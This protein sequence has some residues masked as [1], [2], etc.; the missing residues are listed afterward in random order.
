MVGYLPHCTFNLNPRAASIDTPLHAFVPL[1]ACRPH[2]SRRGHRHRR[3]RRIRSALTKEIFGDEIGWL[4]WQRP[5]FELGLELEAIRRGQ[6]EANGVVLESHGL[7]TWGD[8]AK[9]MLR[10]DAR[11]SSTRRSP[12]STAQTAGKPAFG[13]ARRS[14]RS[15]A[16]ERRAIAAR[17]MPAIRGLISKSERKVGHSTISRRARI[18][19]LRRSRRA[20]RARHLLPRP[21]PAHQDPAAGPR[22][23][24]GSRDVDAVI[25]RLADGARRLSRRLRRLLRALQARRTSP[26]MRDPNAVVYLV[27]GV[28]M[29][30][31][32]SD[33]ATARIAGEFYVNAINVMR[34]ASSVSTYRRPARAGGLRHRVLAAR[35][36]QA[37]AHAEAEEP[38]RP[39]RARHRR[40]RRHRPRHGRRGCCARAPASCSPTSTQAALDA[41]V[42]EFGKRLRQGC[43]ARRRRSTSPTRSGVVAAFAEAAVEFG[44]IDILVSNAGIASSAPIEDTTLAIWDQQ[45]G[46]PRDRLFPGLARGVPPVEARRGLGGAIVFV[47]SKNGLAAS[48]NAAAYCTAKA[49]EIHLARCLAL[50]GA[51][52]RHPRQRRSIPTPCCAA[53]RSGPANGASSAP[54]PTR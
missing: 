19:Q 43:R 11:A 49:A 22:L 38:C 31:F 13:G 8:D 26:P 54:P 28:G 47:A 51:P 23:R 53:R 40:R 27:P 33:K 3:R 12:G 32:A 16:A 24:P 25:A 52:S 42:A 30:T 37:A 5:G 17:L 20:G 46:H 35:G 44:G 29:I 9:A 41:A 34:G 6:P 14:E 39:H 10:D 4:P 50:E 1:R 45:H 48:P 36:G 2:A 7:F 18:R 15:P 21:F